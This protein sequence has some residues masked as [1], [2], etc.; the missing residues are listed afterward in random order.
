MDYFYNLYRQALQ[1][2]TAI[3]ATRSLELEK[4]DSRNLS[5][6]T[7]LTNL[8]KLRLRCITWSF[9]FYHRLPQHLVNLEE[10]I[11]QTCEFDPSDID[12]FCQYL[13]VT[14]KLRK[15]SI[16]NCNITSEQVTQLL[17]SAKQNKSLEW[18]GLVNVDVNESH[19]DLLV[20]IISTHPTLKF[21]DL[22]HTSIKDSRGRIWTAFDTSSQMK[23]VFVR[24]CDF[25]VES[26]GA[27]FDELNNRR[28]D[29]RSGRLM[30]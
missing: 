4:M 10:L 27:S 28:R 29:G 7:K 12:S 15:L 21:L 30:K 13:I 22:A 11:L 19:E 17:E 9:G 20:E 25:L 1:S 18:L 5:D 14:E 8:Q 6:L 23:G 2:S 3:A 24:E 16:E 26:L